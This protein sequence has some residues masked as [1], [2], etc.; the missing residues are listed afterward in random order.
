M[1]SRSM[2][3][4]CAVAI[5]VVGSR[6]APPGAG[7]TTWPVRSGG[8][9]RR[10]SV[11]VPRHRV[12]RQP[13]P[14]V[15]DIHGTGSN[16]AEELEVSG[17]ARAAEE[18]SF[19]VVLPI[20]CVPHPNGGTGWNIP[21]DPHEPDDVRYVADVLDDVSRRL[22]VDSRRIYVTGFSGGARL[23]SEV[24]SRLSHRI[25]ALGAVGGLRAPSGTGRPVAVIAFHGVDDPV[26]PYEGEG[27]AYWGYGLSEAVQGWARRSHCASLDTLR[28]AAG[29]R[30]A[31]AIGCDGSNELRLYILDGAGHVW[32]GSRFAL[33]AERFGAM[34]DAIDATALM[35]DF[36][37]R[38]P[39]PK[40]D[41]SPMPPA[42]GRR[43]LSSMQ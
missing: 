16:P 28:V 4:T 27:P 41:R 36:F 40:V 2:L 19:V 18:R 24:A 35:L 5:C 1:R 22:D 26:N 13:C 12:D 38:H 37:A 33:P 20:A 43:W 39:L 8:V 29:V 23:A 30:C 15:V 7:L 14:I 25:A 42:A 32:P 3:L 9:E 10:Y 31:R 6:P 17:M 21:A 34:T 11:Y